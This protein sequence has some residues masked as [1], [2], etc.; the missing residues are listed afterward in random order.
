MVTTKQQNMHQ[1]KPYYLQEVYT[2]SG[3]RWKK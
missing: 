2:Q 3:E 1:I